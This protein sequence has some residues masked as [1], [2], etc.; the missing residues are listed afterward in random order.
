MI[1]TVLSPLYAVFG[2]REEKRPW[3]RSRSPDS[4]WA[5]SEQQTSAV[6]GLTVGLVPSRH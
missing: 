6:V 3:T 1:A 2:P 4:D 5:M